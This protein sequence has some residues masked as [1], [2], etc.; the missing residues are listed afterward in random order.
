[1]RRVRSKNGLPFDTA[2]DRA[3]ARGLDKLEY[4]AIKL[5]IRT[6]AGSKMTIL[7]GKITNAEYLDALALFE[8]LSR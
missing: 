4:P 5:E 3:K 2:Q 7:V 1:M 8:K 6:R